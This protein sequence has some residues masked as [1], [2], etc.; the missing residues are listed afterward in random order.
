MQ[1]GQDCIAIGREAMD[2]STSGYQDACIAIGSY[3][4]ESQN[5]S[6]YAKNIAIGHQAMSAS[7]E[8]THTVAIGYNAMGGNTNGDYNVAI[9]NYAMARNGS[10][11]NPSHNV[12]I[13]YGAYMNVDLNGDG[14]NCVIG[15]EAATSLTTGT[16]N[17]IIGTGANVDTGGRG[18]S[19]IIGAAATGQGDNY[20]VIGNGNTA[21]VYAGDDAGGTFYGAG[22]SWSDAR[23][24]ENVKDIGLG[25]DFI[26]KL[27]PIQ[28]TKKQPKDYDD[29]LKSKI[30]S[31]P[32]QIVR[33]IDEIEKTRIRP[34][35]LAQDVLEVLKEF[36]FNSHN[37][38]VQIDDKT[39]E[40]SMDYQ[41]MVVPLVKAVQE[42]SEQNKAL[43]KRIE[44]LEK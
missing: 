10:S 3:A 7:V 9:G 13:G 2:A 25:L 18:H 21:R 12:A 6:V 1:G 37:S 8:M 26:N 33:D 36:K 27:E 39:T 31:N 22:Q 19:I 44:E 5:S 43:E 15:D 32:E 34:G 30:Y 17:T 38:I 20:H 42:L 28:Y 29:S 41:G 24:K 4:M 40:H 23:I 11:A 35:F 14:N 16:H